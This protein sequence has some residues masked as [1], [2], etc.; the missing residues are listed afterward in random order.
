MPEWAIVVLILAPMAA[1][2][3][4]FVVGTQT[5]VELCKLNGLRPD[6]MPRSTLEHVARSYAAY[7]AT[8][9]P[10][11]KDCFCVECK[12]ARDAKE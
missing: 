1:F 12:A 7:L 9:N 3:L 10:P 2:L 8:E 6:I 5:E 4:G 11:G